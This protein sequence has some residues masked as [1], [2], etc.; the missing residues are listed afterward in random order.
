MKHVKVDYHFLRE[1]IQKKLLEVRFISTNDQVIDGFTKALPQG[2][3][4]EFQ[5]NLNLVQM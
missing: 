1:C 5:C 2:R 3:L 4:L